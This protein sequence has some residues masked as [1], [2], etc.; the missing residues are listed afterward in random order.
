MFISVG[1][2]IPESAIL[3]IEGNPSSGFF[4]TK[5]FV[6]AQGTATESTYFDISVNI[7]SNSKI[8]ATSLRIDVAL[9]SSNGGTSF[10]AQ[11]TG[12]SSLLV[13][14]S[15]DFAKN[16]KINTFHDAVGTSTTGVANLRV[17][18]N[19]DKTFIAGGKIT[20]IVYYQS[21]ASMESVP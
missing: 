4:T 17:T 5:D 10:T 19:G 1:P 6:E 8:L 15:G 11:Y 3:P 20:A 21:L 16:T 13:T 2:K 7:P 12:G 14:S 9:S 18:C